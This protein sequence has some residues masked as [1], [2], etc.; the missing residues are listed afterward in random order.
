QAFFLA[1]D[2]SRMVQAAQ[3]E[4]DPELR[5]GGGRKL[6]FMG[7]KDTLETKYAEETD[8]GLKEEEFN[9]HFINGKAHMMVKCAKTEKDPEL[10][11]RAVEKLSLMN[12]KEGSDYLIE[13][14][15]K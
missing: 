9:A 15:N 3:A 7:K 13:L 1:G 2:A 6:G 11:K 8:K 12:S 14:L 4:K 5:R 10:R